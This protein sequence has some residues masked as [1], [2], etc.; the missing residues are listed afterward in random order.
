MAKTS[1][2]Q[3]PTGGVTSPKGFVAGG[4]ACG[5]KN[6]ES[7]KKDLCMIYSKEACASAGTFTKNRVKAAP[8]RLSQIHL[9]RGAPSYT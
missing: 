6:P 8:V 5:I 1:F 7:E 4:L 9:Q 2:K 3:L